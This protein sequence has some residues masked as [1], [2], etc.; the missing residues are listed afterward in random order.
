[1]LVVEAVETGEILVEQEQIQE[2]LVVLVLADQH[3]PVLQGPGT[4]GTVATGGGGGG[5]SAG[6]NPW[7]KDGGSGGSGIVIIA[8]PS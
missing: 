6:A 7:W 3:I 1:M 2:D 4:P 8:Y 5:G